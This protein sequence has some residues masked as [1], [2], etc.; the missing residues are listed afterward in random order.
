MKKKEERR[1]R[2]T[3]YNSFIVPLCMFAVC[4]AQ[5]TGVCLH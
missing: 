1:R 2:G 4:F 3:I 5:N